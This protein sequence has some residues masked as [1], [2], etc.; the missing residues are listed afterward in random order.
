MEDLEEILEHLDSDQTGDE[1]RKENFSL[2]LPIY[3][4]ESGKIIQEDPDG[5]KWVVIMDEN[6][7]ITKVQAW[8]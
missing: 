3:Y 2:G 7:K 8:N 1:I 6:R 4:A 5:K